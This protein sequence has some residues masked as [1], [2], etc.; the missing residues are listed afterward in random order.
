MHNG[1]TL[2]GNQDH[3]YVGQ[4]YGNVDFTD[5]VIHWSENANGSPWG[6]D[7]MRFV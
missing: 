7:R 4:K 6:T 1:I 3:S 5:M 2:T